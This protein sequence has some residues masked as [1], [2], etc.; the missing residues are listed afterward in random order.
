MF[1]LKGDM[2]GR[3]NYP[4]K[5]ALNPIL[6]ILFLGGLITALRKY[7]QFYNQY[8]LLYFFLSLILSIIGRTQD[9]PNMLRTF[10]AIPAVVYFIG[11]AYLLLWQLK[12][13]L[14][15]EFVIGFIAILFI[16]STVYEIRTYF[17]FQSRVFRN[18]FEV[19]C[20]L[21]EVIKYDTKKIPLP[22][23]VSKNLF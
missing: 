9:N 10:T 8:F 23:R 5:P 16:V 22:C 6:G 11:Q 1:N 4:G 2:N 7:S 21:Q 14:K 18:S 13:Y 17:V 19:L 15:K 3:H 12:T 20:S